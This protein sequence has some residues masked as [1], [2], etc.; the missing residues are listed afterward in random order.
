[1]ACDPR[2]DLRA[3]SHQGEN[4]G[5]PKFYNFHRWVGLDRQ[6]GHPRRYRAAATE[7]AI[8]TAAGRVKR[9]ASRGKPRK[10]RGPHVAGRVTGDLLLPDSIEGGGRSNVEHRTLNVERCF[11]ILILLLTEVRTLLSWCALWA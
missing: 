11:L 6:A 2:T 9:G 1:M 8:L 4:R 7:R 10:R 3:P 5:A